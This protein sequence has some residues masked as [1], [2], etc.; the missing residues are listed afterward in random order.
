[1]WIEK[2]RTFLRVRT[3]AVRK[4]RCSTAATTLLL[5]VA[6]FAAA[7]ETNSV[8]ERISALQ[9]SQSQGDAKVRRQLNELLWRES[10]RDV[11]EIE[12]VRFTG[13][14]PVRASGK[15]EANS[16]HV[17]IPALTFLPKNR[18]RQKKLPLIVFAHGEV[19]GNVVTDEE[20]QVVKELVERGYAVVAPDYRGSS[21]Y[22]QDY[23]R[24]IDYG[25]LEIEDMDAARQF[26]LERF[27][28]IDPK[29]A[30][31]VG[32]SH[33][34][35][36]AFL[37]VCAH[38]EHYRACYAGAPVSDLAERIRLRGKDYEQLF[39]APYHIGKTVSEAPDE[40]RRR[41]PAG[42]VNEL[43]TPLLLQANTNDEDVQFVEVSK[44]ITG[45]RDAGKEF[46]LK[47]YTNAPGGHI[48]NRLDTKL[49][50]DSRKEIWAF[51]GKH[52][53]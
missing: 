18:S 13:V 21:G 46:E 10:L 34:G 26:M 47:V 50:C 37:T 39:S 28:F 44:L 22:G 8:E 5:L 7:T 41:S 29:R 3:P 1:M 4:R 25:G 17:I 30:A 14:P 33:G 52:L 16:N 45:L 51:L 53:K 40:Y 49:A 2:V 9:E 23:W 19:H 43:R 48:W 20:W 15:F 38:P 42:H 6:S 24:Q 11:A 31:I 12:Q 36:I 32:W 27:S 35:L